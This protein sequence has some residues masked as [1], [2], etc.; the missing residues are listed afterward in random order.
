M[1][2][3]RT[4]DFVIGE[5]SLYGRRNS[6]GVATRKEGSTGGGVAYDS[7]HH[8]LF[9]RDGSVVAWQPNG[10]ILIFDVHPS[11]IR[12]GP[13]AVAVL[14]QPDF[15]TR[16]LGGVGPRKLASINGLILDEKHQRVFVADGANN[17]ILVWDI[18]PQ[19]L[20]ETPDAMAVI[21]QSDF[22]S[23]KPGV[24][25]DRLTGPD[26]LYYDPA[27]DRLFAADTG[28]HRILVFDVAPGKLKTG[29]SAAAVVGQP[30]FMS[31]DAGVGPDRLT[32]PSR[33]AYDEQNRRLF[34]LDAGNRRLLIFD[35]TPERLRLGSRAAHVLG[36]PDFTSRGPRATTKKFGP[37]T[38]ILDGMHQRLFVTEAA[39]ANRMLVFDVHP[40]RITNNPD[41]LAVLF[42]ESFESTEPRVSHSRETSPRPFL[43]ET[44]GKLYVA[45]GYPGGN[46]ITITDVSPGTLRTG[47]P[48]TDALGHYDDDG[49]V[50]FNERAAYGRVNNRFIYPRSVALDTVDHRLFVND[51]YLNRV[52]VFQLDKDNRIQNRE[53]IV[54]LGQPHDRTGQLR[55]ASARTMQIPLAVAY[56]EA[57]KQLFVGDGWNNRVLVFDAHPGRLK[58]DAEAT[59]VLGKQDFISSSADT[60][61][62][63]INFGVRWGRGITST[64]PTPLGFAVDSRR[65]RLFVSDGG[66]H[67]V[68]VF[69]IKPGQLETGAAALVVIGQ[70]D[71]ASNLPTP[72]DA[73]ARGNFGDDA[74]NIAAERRLDGQ[75]GKGRVTTAT[76]LESPSDLAYDPNHDRLFVTD[77]GNSRVLVFDAR[78]DKLRNGAAAS[79]V[80]GQMD[81]TGG[82]EVRLDTE[83]VGED[84]A[85][86]RMRMPN[87]LAYDVVNN[88]LFV[89]DKGNDRILI[90][91]AAPGKLASGMAATGVI[92]QQDFVTRIPGNGEQEQ[93]LDPRGMAFDSRQQRL[94]VTDSFW[95][96]VMVFDLPRAER[97][98]E[99]PARGLVSFSTLDA[100]NGRL[101]LG[102]QRDA[103][104]AWRGT[105][106]TVGAPGPGAVLVYTKTQQT[107]DPLS[108]R[109]SRML[110]SET[111]VP[112]PQ[113]STDSMAYLDE[114]QGEHVI[115]VSNPSA[116]AVPITF[117]FED[118]LGRL[119]ATR[120]VV[121]GGRLEISARHLFGPPVANRVGTLRMTSTEPVA[122][123]TLQRVRTSRGETLLLAAPSTDGWTPQGGAELTIAGVR[124]GGGFET[125]L[126]LLNP[127]TKVM[128]GEVRF[129]GRDGE[130]VQVRPATSLSASRAPTEGPRLTF[131][132]S[133]PGW[134]VSR[135]RGDAMELES[136]QSRVS[137][138]IEPGNAW[139]W[140]LAATDT[141]PEDLYVVIEAGER[142]ATPAASALV[143]LWNGSLLVTQAKT[144]ARAKTEKAWIPIDT[145]PSLI[146]HGQSEMRFS[147]A[148][149]TQ[150]PATL[151]LTLFDPSGAERGRYE[152]LLPARSQREWSLAE[153]FNVQK[154][155]GTLRLVSDVPIAVSAQ[156]ITRS[157]RGEPVRS[158]IGYVDVAAL[159]KKQEVELPEVSDGAGVATELLLINPLPTP[160]RAQLRFTAA[161]GQPAAVILR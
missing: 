84:V 122:M 113:P 12:N 143:N 56:D 31:G 59:A 154:M 68:L 13:D 148:N 39:D 158:E 18:H 23:S 128:T 117:S 54:I 34:V 120:G 103:R 149:S 47:M 141:L 112:S 99:V 65:G 134:S 21:G 9:V 3:R 94:Y 28:N 88:R 123:V 139:V 22:M 62:A 109:R 71:F 16:T 151:R 119:D 26:G 147:F 43:N 82:D 125:A 110:I 153:L 140:P 48:A 81:F 75:A 157:L 51:Q 145:L 55:A 136:G 83:K 80:L 14:G 8:R 111:S 152:Q 66:N 98:V 42:Q 29:M 52:L 69:D 35:G 115:I 92:G 127:D 102:S 105:L 1:P 70:P 32:R 101:D 96:R 36:Q 93:L 10:R 86:R 72:R 118:D 20:T 76:G 104:Q 159:E 138:R 41:A 130:R 64:S 155:R 146:R 108:K 79:A 19:R 85:R 160:N 161:S 27:T 17:R 45:S 95:A 90:F 2:L 63:G 33:L 97:L 131:A 58:T 7:V 53:A 144:P 38:M 114:R 91:E 116:A 5:P 89:G 40:S 156:R 142:S 74:P 37:G 25:P 61:P 87:G 46:R 135:E 6:P 57:T 49:R 129:Y 50:D 121:A 30:D 133:R 100:W 77:G 126:V 44:T 4:A 78:S 137:Y 150:T 132:T 15:T 60:G 73:R 67:R 124:R 106:S 24:G 107:M 11:R